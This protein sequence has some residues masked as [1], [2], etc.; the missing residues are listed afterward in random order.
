[1]G[2]PVLRADRGA[3][4]KTPLC[5]EGLPFCPR[6]GGCFQGHCLSQCYDTL[7]GRAYSGSF[8]RFPRLVPCPV[9]DMTVSLR[10]VMTHFM[11]QSV[12]VEACGRGLRASLLRLM[13]WGAWLTGSFS[14][15]LPASL[16]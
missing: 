8:Q 1:M 6:W 13:C 3:W 9:D 2:C 10:V 5:Q 15:A 11:Q 12:M 4:K 14:V 16:T 7:L